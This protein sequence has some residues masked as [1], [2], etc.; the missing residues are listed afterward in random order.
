M[1]GF[2][3]EG[4]TARVSVRAKTAVFQGLTALA[5]LLGW[6]SEAHAQ[7]NLCNQATLIVNVV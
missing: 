1:A 7:L 4:G 2:R 6:S 3:F 5:L